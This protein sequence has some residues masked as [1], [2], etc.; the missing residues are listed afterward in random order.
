MEKFLDDFRTNS[1]T[2][3]RVESNDNGIITTTNVRSVVMVPVITRYMPKPNE[4]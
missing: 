2:S 1:K 4:L 3:K